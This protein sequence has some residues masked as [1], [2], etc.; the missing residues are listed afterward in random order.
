[1]LAIQLRAIRFTR[2]HGSPLQRAACKQLNTH[3]AS[4]SDAKLAGKAIN[5]YHVFTHDP[6]ARAAQRAARPAQVR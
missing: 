4:L 5:G 1:M 3:A 6:D 2:S